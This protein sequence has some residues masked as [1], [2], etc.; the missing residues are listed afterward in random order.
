[1]NVANLSGQL[2]PWSLFLHADI[3]VKAIIV[4]LAL[5]SVVSWAVIGDKLIRFGWLKRQADQWL[6]ILQNRQPLAKL[7]AETAQ[8]P[9]DPF[10]RIYRAVLNEW[11]ESHSQGL[12]GGT[13]GSDGLKD[14]LSRVAQLATGGELEAAQRGL[15]LLATI[16]SVSPFVGLF[17]TVWGIIHAFQGIAASNNT[18]LAVVAPGIAEALFATALGLVAAIPAVIA[19]NRASGELNSYANRLGTLSGLVE[20]QLARL[21]DG[22]QSVIGF[23]EPLAPRAPH[24]TTAL[25]SHDADVGLTAQAG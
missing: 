13:R 9:A 14:R 4:L 18:S 6:R 17:G 2:S 5:A 23:D 25:R 10:S 22:G 19:Y 3:V 20:I 8:Y 11:D 16:G 24:Q 1:M 7:S 12:V 15:S 21:V